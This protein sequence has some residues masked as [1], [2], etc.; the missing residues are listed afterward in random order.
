M[1]PGNVARLETTRDMSYKDVRDDIITCIDRCRDASAS[2][3][4]PL[5]NRDQEEEGKYAHHA[6]KFQF[7]GGAEGP[8]G[9]G[10]ESWRNAEGMC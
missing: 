6:P 10:A 4:I 8:S 7:L 2:G 9:I 3:P 5:D 1:P